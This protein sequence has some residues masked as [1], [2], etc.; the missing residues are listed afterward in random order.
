MACTL[1]SSCF[2]QWQDDAE[3][4]SDTKRCH[5]VYTACSINGEIPK[6]SHKDGNNQGYGE[7]GYKI[8]D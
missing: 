2:Y 4:E 3:N 8:N 1:T 7:H 6:K 5:P